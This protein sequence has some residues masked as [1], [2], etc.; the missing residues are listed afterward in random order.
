[1]DWKSWCRF[2]GNLEGN[3]VV[4]SLDLAIV[5]QVFEVKEKNSE[6]FFFE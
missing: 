2:C 1:M 4:E 5:D 3:E 6:I